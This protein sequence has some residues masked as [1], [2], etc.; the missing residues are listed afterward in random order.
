MADSNPLHRIR[1]AGVG[2]AVLCAVASGVAACGGDEDAE[3]TRPAAAK[4]APPPVDLE[5]S[6]TR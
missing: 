6:P 5:K 2:A 1:M 4:A 3:R